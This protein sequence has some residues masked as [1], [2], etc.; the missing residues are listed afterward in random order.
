[1]E[2]NDYLLDWDKYLSP[3]RLRNEEKTFPRGDNRASFETDLRRVVFCPALRRMHDKTQVIPLSN[4]DTLLT[5][6]THS[7]HVMD[8]AEMIAIRL[9]RCEG[10]RKKY[11]DKADIYADSILSIMR[12][13]ALIHDIGNPPFG[14]FGEVSIQ[15]FFRRYLNSRHI[16]TDEESYDFTE[17]DGNALGLRIV[18]KLQYTGTLDGLNLTYA[19]LGA[20]LKYPNKGKS[21]PDGYV[22]RHK[23]GVFKTESDLFDK[24][25]NSCQLRGLDGEIKR[26]PLSFLVEAADSI[27][28]GVTDI[29]DGYSLGWYDLDTIVEYLSVFIEKNADNKQLLDPYRVSKKTGK[30]RKRIFSVEKLVNFSR[31]WNVGGVS[32]PKDSRRLFVDFRD[33]LIDYLV[34]QVCSAFESNLEAIDNGS[35][36]EELLHVDSFRVSKAL[37]DFAWRYIITNREVQKIEMTGNSVI[38]GLLEILLKYCFHEEK[39]YRAKINAIIAPSRQEELIHEDKHRDLAVNTLEKFEEREKLWDYDIENLSPYSK[40]RVIVDFVGSM[41]DKYS[42]ELYQRLC[43]MKL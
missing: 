9:T 4:G 13:A 2:K 7:L 8:V 12:T 29:E 14:H 31:D 42:V 3:N 33:K 21:E 16:V 15:N 41:T 1:M 6:L 37:S 25:V 39:K 5:R 18:S 35:F 17:F 38:S 40:L 24:I 36:G 10:F 20:Y 32:A 19:T 11:K 43:G 22:G 30:G 23:H 27:C 34:D 26:H 28:Y